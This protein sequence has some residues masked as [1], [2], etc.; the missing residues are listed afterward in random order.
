MPYG[1]HVSTEG[2]REA[3]PDLSTARARFEAVHRAAEL[4]D[5]GEA[6]IEVAAA[7]VRSVDPA[8]QFDPHQA[9]VAVEDA[10][11]EL[12]ADAPEEQIRQAEIAAA[13]AAMIAPVLAASTLISDGMRALRDPDNPTDVQE[14]R[15][16]IRQIARGMRAETRALDDPEARIAGLSWPLTDALKDCPDGCEEWVLAGAIRQG[17]NDDELRLLDRAADSSTNPE[18]TDRWNIPPPPAREWIAPGW[19]PANRVTLLTGEGGRGKSRL[20]MMLAAA[21]AAGARHWF[22]Y[23]TGPEL[24]PQSFPVLFASWEDEREEFQRRL[25]DWPV[26]TG[27]QAP[28]EIDRLLGVRLPFFDMAAVGPVWIAGSHEDEAGALTKAGE[29]LRAEAEDRGARLLILDPLAAAY[30]GNE[31]DRGQVRQFMA[32][33]GAWAALQACA[34][35]IVA[36]P[37]KNTGAVYSGSTDWRNAAR[38]VLVMDYQD[39]CTRLS[40][41]KS[42][43]A[44]EP[45]A[46][47]L[48]DWKWWQASAWEGN[49]PEDM[50]TLIRRALEDGPKNKTELQKAVKRE[51]DAVRKTVDRMLAAGDIED[52]GN[53]KFRLSVYPSEPSDG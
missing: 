52:A 46:L 31:N 15:Q 38:S 50:E 49:A 47:A 21:K 35:L 18:I 33:W 22:A 30:S 45:D 11:A 36:H 39:G 51:A 6:A 44:P 4:A 8:A 13:R 14:R 27:K 9:R 19:I 42:S 20:A 29:L 32:N 10:F 17:L 7:V 43:Y 1:P 37:P 48:R 24:D 23:E 41:D 2:G 28:P 3:Q 53:R 26:L 40:C 16:A 34:V 12:D 5:A 25:Y